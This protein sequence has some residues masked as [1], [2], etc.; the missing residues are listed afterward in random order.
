MLSEGQ[1]KSLLFPRKD[2]PNVISVLKPRFYPIFL[3]IL[4]LILHNTATNIVN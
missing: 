3:S 2:F 4:I 1:K